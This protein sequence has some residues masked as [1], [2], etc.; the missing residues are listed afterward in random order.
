MPDGVLDVPGVVSFGRTAMPA[1]LFDPVSAQLLTT[2]AINGSQRQA[3][4][5][6]FISAQSRLGYLESKEKIGTREAQAMQEVR[7]SAQAREILQA[8]AASDQPKA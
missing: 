8:R 5:A 6:A 2:H 4:D 7:T 1:D 3:D